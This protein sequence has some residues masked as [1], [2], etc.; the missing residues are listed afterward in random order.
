MPDYKETDTGCYTEH[1][2]SG[3]GV[4]AK[5]SRNEA[6]TE[7]FLKAM[8]EQMMLS[9]AD[10]CIDLGAKCIGHIKSHLKTD[11]LEMDSGAQLSVSSEVMAILAVS[12]DL[13]DMRRRMAK[14]V[15][16]YD[17]KGNHPEGFRNVLFLDFHVEW[18]TEPPFCSRFW[19]AHCSD[20]CFVQLFWCGSIFFRAELP[21]GI[22]FYHRR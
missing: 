4:A 5:L 19:R 8:T 2:V 3:Y 7:A 14:I 9:I 16:A 18:S 11:G 17:K 1:G 6:M 21:G 12:K 15:V 22:R 13:A 10:K 20:R